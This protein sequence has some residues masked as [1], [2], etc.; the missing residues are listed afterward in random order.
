MQLHNRQLSK[1]PGA[2][3]YC[4]LR[5]AFLVCPFSAFR[6][7]FA[8]NRITLS[9][10]CPCGKALDFRVFLPSKCVDRRYLFRWRSASFFRRTCTAQSGQ[11]LARLELGRKGR[12]ADG[13][14][15]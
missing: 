2:G 5:P 6:T 14:A 13:A 1:T 7:R 4:P 12:P 10:C 15:F 8:G 9:I 3:L 11:Y